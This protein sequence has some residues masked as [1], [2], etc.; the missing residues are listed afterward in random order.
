[1]YKIYWTDHKNTAQGIY[2]ST[3]QGALRICEEKRR[4]GFSFV[5]MV[6]ENPNS[7]GKPGVDAVENGKCP[8]GVD[9]TWKKRR[10]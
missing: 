10:I 6:S 7:V 5:T 4:E 2:T 8:D 3:L 9:Y 1:M